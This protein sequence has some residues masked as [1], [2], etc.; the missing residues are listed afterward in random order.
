MPIRLV[1]LD[2]DG[3]LVDPRGEISPRNCKAISEASYRGVEI[4][5]V[6]GRRYHSAS[7]FVEQMPVPVTVISSN[8]ARIGDSEGRAFYRNL[9]PRAV[10]REIVGATAAYQGYL[11]AFFDIPGRG[12]IVMHQDAA[13]DGLVGWYLKTCPECLLQTEDLA[14]SVERNPLH[15]TFAGPPAVI[16]A[17]EPVLRA[18]PLAPRF[19]LTWTKY[20]ARNLSLL[21][22]MNWN[23]SKGAGLAYWTKRRDISRGEVLAIGDNMND[24]EMLEFAGQPVLMANHNFDPVPGGWDVTSS[25]GEDGVALAIERYVLDGRSS[26]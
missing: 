6:T 26:T 21:D 10:A 24:L 13:P 5:I 22:T 7:R 16:E 4:V 18:S 12:Q 3:T 19:H 14:T 1:A 2:L 9:L 11:A 8:G 23:C 20:L 25:N 17:I 15:L